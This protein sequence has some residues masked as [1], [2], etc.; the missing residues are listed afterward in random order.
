MPLVIPEAMAF[1]NVI[2]GSSHHGMRVA[3]EDGRIGRLHEIGNSEELG[4]ILRDLINNETLLEELSLASIIK[5]NKEFE[6]S[7]IVQHIFKNFYNN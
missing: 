3:T 4:N 7:K 2:V 1:G 6:W 5:A